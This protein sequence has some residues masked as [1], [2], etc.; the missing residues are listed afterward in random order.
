M[1]TLSPSQEDLPRNPKIHLKSTEVYL[2]QVLNRKISSLEAIMDYS[3]VETVGM[4]QVKE[5]LGHGKGNSLQGTVNTVELF[6]CEADNFRLDVEFLTMVKLLLL[7]FFHPVVNRPYFLIA[8]DDSSSD[9]VVK[10]HGLRG[11]LHGWVDTFLAVSTSLIGKRPP[12]RLR[13]SLSV[14]YDLRLMPSAFLGWGT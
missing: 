2:L 5:L 6:L 4:E 14:T 10:L 1:V 7:P 11:I 3:E 12:V 9:P 13:T 8:L